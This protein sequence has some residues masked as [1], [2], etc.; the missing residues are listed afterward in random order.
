M[1]I[2]TKKQY[3]F[4]N[5]DIDCYIDDWI[6]YYN[7]ERYQWDLAKLSPCEYYEYITT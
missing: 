1:S 6:Y 7:H 4:I 5:I 3:P 2:N